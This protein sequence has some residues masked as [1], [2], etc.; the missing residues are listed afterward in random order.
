[1]RKLDHATVQEQLIS[2]YIGR[3]YGPRSKTTSYSP[4]VANSAPVRTANIISI[5]WSFG[6]S[7]NLQVRFRIF[8]NG[9]LSPETN[10]YVYSDWAETFP[11]RLALLR[12]AALPPREAVVYLDD[13]RPR[14]PLS[15]TSEKVRVLSLSIMMSLTVGL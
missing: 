4:I 9:R 1:M 13:G 8:Q 7:R 14:S 3:Y 10:S 5:F 15:W 2:V 12:W 6:S 11:G